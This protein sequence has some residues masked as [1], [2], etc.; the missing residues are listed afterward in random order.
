[1]S[2]AKFDIRQNSGGNVI[3]TVLQTVN[4]TTG[5]ALS[6]TLTAGV[7]A[8]SG[9]SASITPRYA[10][11]KIAIIWTF[12]LQPTYNSNAATLKVFLYRS[13]TKI[14]SQSFGFHNSPSNCER[15]SPAQCIQYFD[16]PNT[17]SSTE[18][19]IYLLAALAN[20]TFYVNRTY[21]DTSG[22][23]ASCVL[24]EIAQ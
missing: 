7:D 16:S 14:L 18:Y 2:I 10:S 22:Y 12:G 3:N 11:S 13:T 21:A 4:V 23:T 20:A 15:Y 17:T 1:M 24:L 6:W 9:L 5:T 19:R 8:N